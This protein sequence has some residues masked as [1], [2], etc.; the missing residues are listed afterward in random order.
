MLIWFG[1][2]QSMLLSYSN[3][4]SILIWYST[5]HALCYGMAQCTA[6]GMVLWHSIVW[7]DMFLLCVDGMVW[8]REK[9]KAVS[10]ETVLVWW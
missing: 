3:L 10:G 4:Q 5:V 6:H 7:Q 9:S 2:L 8:E 1:V